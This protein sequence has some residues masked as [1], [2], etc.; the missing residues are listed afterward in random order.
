MT[1]TLVVI[2]LLT[3]NVAIEREN[4]SLHACIGQAAMA[5]KQFLEVQEQLQP[6]IGDVR[7]FCMPE[8]KQ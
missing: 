5:K 3:G 4:L 2:F 1:Y 6:R 7:F 8:A